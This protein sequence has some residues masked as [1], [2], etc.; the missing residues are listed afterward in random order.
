MGQA[1]PMLGGLFC[2]VST[3]RKVGLASRVALSD[4]LRF[5]LKVMEERSH[6]GLDAQVTQILRDTILSQIERVEALIER[7][8][9]SAAVPTGTESSVLS[10]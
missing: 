7:V 8:R 4:F 1:H 3:P 10:E 9:V 6:L 5:A 2:R